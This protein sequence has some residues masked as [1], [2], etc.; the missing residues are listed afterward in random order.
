MSEQLGNSSENYGN[1]SP[2]ECEALRS[3]LESL[4]ASEGMPAEL[5][6]TQVGLEKEGYQT[7][8]FETE[9]DAVRDMQNHIDDEVENE[10]KYGDPVDP[11]DGLPPCLRLKR[12]KEDQYG[13][14]ESENYN[15]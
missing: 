9:K 10:N 6:S 13:S 14:S 15:E 7:V 12:F 3:A 4:L 11:K 1:M 2:E 8:G 5:E